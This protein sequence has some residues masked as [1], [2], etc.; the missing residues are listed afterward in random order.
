V[1]AG[2]GDTVPITK[3]PTWEEID[4]GWGDESEPGEDANL[5]DTNPGFMSVQE[6]ET[7]RDGSG[8]NAPARAAAPSQDDLLPPDEAPTQVED[9]AAPAGSRDEART[10]MGIG[11]NDLP[12]TDAATLPSAPP[13]PAQPVMGD[14]DTMPISA[15]STDQAQLPAPPVERRPAPP[16]PAL[17]DEP[18]DPALEP[19][20]LAPSARPTVPASPRAVAQA[21]TAQEEAATNELPHILPVAPPPSAAPAPQPA[22]PPPSA[23]PAPQPRPVQPSA[24]TDQSFEERP[25]GPSN[26]PLIIVWV[27]ALASVA[28]AAALWLS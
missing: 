25:A 15:L 21:P 23:A 7:L 24:L 9:A 17:V 12:T 14:A 5:R 28:F 4:D 10:V 26:V 20:A 13:A 6:A 1:E 27:L 2:A 8:Q 16:D 3:Q 19:Q 18:T 11:P 22:A